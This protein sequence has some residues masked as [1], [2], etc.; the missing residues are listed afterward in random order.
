M[1]RYSAIP[2]FGGDRVILAAGEDKDTATAKV[3]ELLDHITRG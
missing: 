2:H 1:I 3:A